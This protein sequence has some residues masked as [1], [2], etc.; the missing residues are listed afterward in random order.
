MR[1]TFN[2]L[3]DLMGYY[4]YSKYSVDSCPTLL[5]KKDSNFKDQ[6]NAF[7]N[8]SSM[9]ERLAFI[10]DIEI[11]VKVFH[12]KLS[13]R[14]FI[15]IPIEYLFEVFHFKLCRDMWLDK[16]FLANNQHHDLFKRVKWEDL[17]AK[18]HTYG[19]L[20]KR[21]RA[22]LEKEKERNKI[23]RRLLNKGYLWELAKE[24]REQAEE[25]YIRLGYLPEKEDYE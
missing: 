11:F 19:Q 13:E 21:F 16:Y 4:Q 1:E 9:E 18:Y 24:M 5:P 12:A 15:P 22:R 17:R 14:S 10:G 3:G 8:R 6:M 7:A 2:S 25:F 23:P 20:I